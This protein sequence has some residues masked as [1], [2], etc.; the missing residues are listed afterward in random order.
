MNRH[1]KNEHNTK[2]YK[3]F[4]I[5]QTKNEIINF[6]DKVLLCSKNNVIILKITCAR[7]VK[8][9][10]YG[11]NADDDVDRLLIEICDY[12]HPSDI[13]SIYVD[14]INNIVYFN[15]YRFVY[16]QKGELF[17]DVNTFLQTMIF[18]GKHK[19]YLFLFPYED[20]VKKFMD[21]LN[22]KTLKL[23][24]HIN[25]YGSEC[26][27]ADVM[28]KQKNYLKQQLSPQSQS[29][30]QLYRQQIYKYF[31]LKT[32]EN[33][34]IGSPVPYVDGENI[35][36]NRI[37]IIHLYLTTYESRI[38]IKKCLWYMF[39]PNYKTYDML[40]VDSNRIYYGNDDC[41]KNK[42]STIYC[43]DGIFDGNPIS[44][45][46]NKYNDVFNLT[47]II[48]YGLYEQDK[49][50]WHDFL[51]HEPYDPRLFLFIDLFCSK[52]IKG[53]DHLYLAWWD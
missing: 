30:I 1:R 40:F 6:M 39:D 13:G 22:E 31:R 33:N 8:C 7:W 52:I 21:L 11:N 23:L 4:N 35:E 42:Y 25:F 3:N 43:T 10:V 19:T 44:V 9:D 18:R 29:Q 17:I 50:T 12:T 51:T 45:Y 46:K 14:F 16:H 48:T 47:Q 38:N 2:R 24:T 20:Y 37:R 27:I 5:K 49:G 41:N 28:K 53:R 15:D 26:P 34:C 36:K 32:K